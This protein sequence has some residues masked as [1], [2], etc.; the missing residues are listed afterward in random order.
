M[1]SANLHGNIREQHVALCQRLRG[2]INYFGYFGVSGNIRRI[3]SLV[4]IAKG[5]WHMGLRGR[6][7]RSHITWSRFHG[8]PRQFP[9][10]SSENRL[11]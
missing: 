2:P 3:G 11:W 5:V 4:D 9:M 7:P 1:R 10:P 8:I 6:S